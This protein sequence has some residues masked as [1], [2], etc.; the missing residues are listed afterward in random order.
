MTDDIPP[1]N[2]QEVNISYHLLFWLTLAVGG[3]SGAANYF[4]LRFTYGM[5][6]Y[7][8]APILYVISIVIIYIITCSNWKDSSRCPFRPYMKYSGTWII[9]YFVVG[10]AI[11]WF[12]W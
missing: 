12:G 3:I 4:I 9:A 8:L 10:T 11:F 5:P 7:M 6:W 1:P 2:G